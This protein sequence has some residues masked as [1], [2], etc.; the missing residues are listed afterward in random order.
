M[1]HTSAPSAFKQDAQD[2]QDKRKILY[3]LC[4][5]L[6]TLGFNLIPTNRVGAAGT[7]PPTPASTPTA[8]TRTDL[9]APMSSFFERLAPPP[10][11]YPPTQADQGAQVYYL[12]CMV[13]HGDRGQGLTEDWRNVLDPADRNCWQSHCHASNHPLEG[14]KLPK[15]VPAIIGTGKLEP[16]QNALDLHDYL[17]ARMPWQAPGSLSEDEYWQL[18]AY[19]LRENGFAPGTLPLDSERAAAISLVATPTPTPTPGG[20]LTGFLDFAGGG[21]WVAT[22]L[23]LSLIMLV[24]LMALI[25]RLSRR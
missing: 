18:T 24:L 25:P 11:V 7:P 10:T 4:I 15:Y 1:A 6:I 21:F 13:C 19:L 9:P 2:R 14:F 20:S 12:V 5:L 3:I 22:T 17:Q 16:F 23:V 8:E